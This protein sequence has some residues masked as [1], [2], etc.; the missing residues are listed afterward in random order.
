MRFTIIKRSA[1]II[2]GGLALIILSPL[3]II[4]ILI[5]SLSAE[6]EIFYFQKRIGY[7]NHPFYIFKFATMIKNS[8]IMGAG[9]VTLK[10]DPR[11]TKIGKHL[12]KSKLNEVPQLI[13]VLKGEMSI[14]GPRPVDDFAF[15]A[16]PDKIASKIYNIKPG[17]TGIGS[18]VFRDEESTLTRP[19]IDPKEFYSNHIAPYK[20][21]LELWYHDHLSF[22]T[23]LLIIF[24]TAWQILFPDSNLV[25]KIF[26]DLPPKPKALQLDLME[27][28]NR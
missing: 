26:K 24:L 8:P 1:D 21:Q 15:Q 16:Y 2:V 3:L 12:R 6:G 7:K 25:F 28:N 4:V 20:G 22:S 23:D 27:T 10:N 11:V 17:I 19:G 13:N 9:A 18:I 5:L 14:I